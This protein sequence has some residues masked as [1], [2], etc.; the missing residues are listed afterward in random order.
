LASLVDR[1]LARGDDAPTLVRLLGWLY[2]EQEKVEIPSSL[3]RIATMPREERR[4]L[5]RSLEQE[6]GP[7]LV[8]CPHCG[9]AL[10]ASDLPEGDMPLNQ[11]AE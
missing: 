8:D 5:L 2:S 6:H 3:D 7:A 4:A 11:A 1:A 9:G 10:L